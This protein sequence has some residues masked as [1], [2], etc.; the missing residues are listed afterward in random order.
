MEESLN[1]DSEESP[2]Q[3]ENEVKS[4]YGEGVDIALPDILLP[5]QIDESKTKKVV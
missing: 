3:Q 5:P 4:L 2:S 1:N